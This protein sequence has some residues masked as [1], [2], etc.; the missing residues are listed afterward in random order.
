MRDITWRPNV[1]EY[2]RDW[3]HEY[4]FGDLSSISLSCF[5]GVSVID[6]SWAKIDET[7]FHRMVA[8]YPRLLPYLVAANPVN[9]GKP[10][11][12]CRV[13]S[14]VPEYRKWHPRSVVWWSD[15]SFRNIGDLLLIIRLIRKIFWKI[16][17][18]CID[19]SDLHAT[20][21]MTCVTKQRW[22]Q[23]HNV[24]ISSCYPRLLT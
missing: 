7:P 12:Y 1:A 17:M 10:C 6:C 15:D 9:Y 8:V 11:R 5:R 16:L 22:K 18:I 20:L 2:L 4:E 21:L 24:I 19:D 23:L 13:D 3:L 14:H